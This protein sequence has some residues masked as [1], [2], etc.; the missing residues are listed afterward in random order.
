MISYRGFTKRFGNVTAVEDLSLEVEAGEV[1]ALLGPNGSGK[2]TAL[3]AAAGLIRP[4]CGEVRVGSCL[5][6][7]GEP[8]ARRSL[9]Y[10]PQKVSF[11][12]AATGRE[13]LELYRRLRGV[14]PERTAEVLRFASLNG[15]G[16]RAVTTYSGGMLQRLGLA[17]ALLPDAPLLLLDEPTAALDPD[18]LCA[19]YGE[20]ERRRR[21]GRTVLFTSHQLG[22]VER[23]ADR[24]AVLVAGRLV[25]VLS[26]QELVE[27]MAERGLLRVRL[28]QPAP[29]LLDEV[30]HFVPGAVWARDE[31]IVPGHA[32]RRPAVLELLHRRG[33][34]IT[35]LSTE[36][37]RLDGLYRELVGG[38]K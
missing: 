27:R 8:E 11:P 29:E 33:A 36:E 20:I 26:Q 34:A 9:S 16:E 18:G 15:A 19:F 28:A 23:I 22:D 13:V 2:T 32:A 12:A 6:P 31:L 7:A 5:Q 14:A 35:G 24:F 4:T 1:V 3:K 21:L 25:A 30:R 17:A 38:G 10:L 37:G